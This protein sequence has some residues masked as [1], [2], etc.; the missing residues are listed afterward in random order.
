MHFSIDYIVQ[1]V[2]NDDA[3]H[4]EV[5]KTIHHAENMQRFLTLAMLLLMGFCTLIAWN[6]DKLQANVQGYSSTKVMIQQM[7]PKSQGIVACTKHLLD[8]IQMK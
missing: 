4:Q 2:E 7:I 5:W 3:L 6:A 1:V 8:S